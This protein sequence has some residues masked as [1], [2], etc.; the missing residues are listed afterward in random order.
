MSF[1]QQ[2]RIIINDY[3]SVKEIEPTFEKKEK[4]RSF[5]SVAFKNN[6]AQLYDVI[7]I[8]EFMYN[9]SPIEIIEKSEQQVS[10]R[11]ASLKDH[12]NEISITFFGNFAEELEDKTTF[13]LTD[14]LRVSKYMN[15][16]LLKTTET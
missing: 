2:R 14:D 11:K 10:L 6:E 12:T 15:I 16:R 5:V 13:S 1:K 9:V 4:K 8:T 3:T 7:N